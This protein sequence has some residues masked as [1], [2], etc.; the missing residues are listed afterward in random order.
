MALGGAVGSRPEDIVFTSGGTEADALAV[1][2]AVAGLDGR[3]T[4]IVSAQEHEAV[5]RAAAH[6]GVPVE[7]LY[8]T[9]AGTVDLDDLEAR[10][11]AGTMPRKARPSLL[12]RRTTRRVFSSRSP[13]RP[14]SSGR[15]A[16]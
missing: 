16:G 3:C 5:G 2:G 10:L 7:T 9:P 13:K 4:L 8:V 11:K 15:P 1:H 14:P 6:A 12:V